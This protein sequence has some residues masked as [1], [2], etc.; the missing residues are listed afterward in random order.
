M[1]FFFFFFYHLVVDS[2]GV[3]EM[4][5]NCRAFVILRMFPLTGDSGQV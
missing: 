1:Y 3:G 5:L 2:K 4:E